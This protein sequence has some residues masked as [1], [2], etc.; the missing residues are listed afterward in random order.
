LRN[1]IDTRNARLIGRHEN[2]VTRNRA[3]SG[4]AG[5]PRTCPRGATV[6]DGSGHLIS[7][8]YLSLESSEAAA[9]V[10]IALEAW[11]ADDLT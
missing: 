10:A 11:V 1:E 6:P 3:T 7:N 5:A 4:R 2:W 8:G 9:P